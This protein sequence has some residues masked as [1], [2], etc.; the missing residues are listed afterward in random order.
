MKALDEQTLLVELARPSP[1]F[2]ELL[3]QPICAPL[4]DVKEKTIT[5]FNGPFQLDKWERGSIL[6]LKQNPHFW[7]IKKVSIPQIEVFMVQDPETAFAL[8][9]NKQIDWIG[10]PMGPLSTEQIHHLKAKKDLHSHPVERAFWVFL[11]TQHK[12]LSSPSI[13]NALSLAIN[14]ETIT[15][16]ILIGSHPLDKPLPYELLPNPT[17][18]KITEDLSQAKKYFEAGLQEMGLT[19]ETFP[20]LVITY[21][22]HANRKQ[23]SEYL[24]QAWS[25]A[26]GINVELQ[27]QEW[28]V[29]RTNLASG[30]FEICGAFEA[31][32]YRDPLELLERMVSINTSN[33][34][35]WVFP[36]FQQKISLASTE[37][38]LE[39]RLALLG[40][41]ENILSEQMPFIP[42]SRDS[43]LFSHHPKLKG[44][45]FDS[46][47]AIDFSYATLR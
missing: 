7:N 36:S 40:E 32:Y 46:L 9:E 16:N 39:Q 23:L 44:Y 21:S 35:Q 5:H 33:F 29:L 10:V 47:G 25:Q 19:R 34:T 4:K 43:F 18:A 28:N 27:P 42:I 15:R 37:V 3:A 22:Q 2:L 30:D 31:S 38:N 41:A 45:T 26:F 20:P 12:A 17:P 1:H 13:R 11:N 6:R 8:Y 14:R 24:Q